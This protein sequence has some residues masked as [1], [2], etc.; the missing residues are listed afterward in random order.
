MILYHSVI[1]KKCPPQKG[2]V[3]ACLKSNAYFAL[4]D[5]NDYI[6]H[7]LQVLLLFTNNTKKFAGGGYVIS[8]INQG[9]RSL[10]KHMLAVDWKT[11]KSYVHPSSERSI[12]IRM[13]E[14]VAGSSF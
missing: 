8:P 9:T 11:W 5:F 1:H 4:A 6:I 14:R 7:F 13:L 12:T 10:V 3:R 2:Y